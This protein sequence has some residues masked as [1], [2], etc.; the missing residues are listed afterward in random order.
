MLVFAIA[1]A[2]TLGE[3]V[4]FREAGRAHFVELAREQA[5]FAHAGC[6]DQERAA[7]Q[8]VKLA[9]RRV[10]APRVGRARSS[11]AA[12]PGRAVH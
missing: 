7:R 2:T 11:R 8:R 1:E 5:E 3:L 9:R 6:V 12:P 10:T 4:D